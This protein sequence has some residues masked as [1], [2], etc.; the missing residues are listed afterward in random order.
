MAKTLDIDL[1]LDGIQKAIDFLKDYEA[2]VGEMTTMLVR[3]M[4]ASGIKIAGGLNVSDDGNE[5]GAL[6]A[7]IEQ[8]SQFVTRATISYKGSQVA[9]IEFGAG[10]G[11]NAPV[12]TSNH[13]YADKF[14]YYIGTYGYGLG[15]FTSW[16]KPNGD[17]SY[18]TTAKM[19]MWTASNYLS[20]MTVLINL[21]RD[22]FGY[23]YD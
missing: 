13:P 20:G 22:V 10:V 21:A 16:R 23:S 3:R 5:P 1:S 2:W 4:T 9:F 17:I 11:K 15:R 18:G 6:S 12:G 14:G 19:P 7:T 8:V